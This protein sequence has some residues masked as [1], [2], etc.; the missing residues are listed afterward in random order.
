MTFTYTLGTAVNDVR[1]RVHG[2][3]NSYFGYTGPQ[4]AGEY[5][6]EWDGSLVNESVELS[7]GI[8][9]IYPQYQLTPG[10]PWVNMTNTGSQG[11][12]AYVRLT[13]DNTP[14]ELLQVTP[15]IS[16]LEDHVI[17]Q[18]LVDDL[19]FGL[20]DIG[21]EVLLNGQKLVVTSHADLTQPG[22]GYD[23]GIFTSDPMPVDLKKGIAFRLQAADL[24]GNTTTEDYHFAAVT[25]DNPKVDRVL[26]GPY[27]ISGRAIPGVQVMINEEVIPLAEDGSFVWETEIV[28][29]GRQNIDIT[30]HVPQWENAKPIKVDLV[31]IGVPN[32]AAAGQVEP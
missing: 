29:L 9:T 2:V 5:S 18:G 15:I 19:M 16:E 12:M 11:A 23:Y 28:E 20:L 26:P 3:S 31:V 8:I 1:F 27:T 17:I 14:P 7:E 6:F 21:G 30:A 13:L 32:E 22:R 25:L 24:A 4:P 10:G